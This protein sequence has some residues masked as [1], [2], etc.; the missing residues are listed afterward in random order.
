M[1]GGYGGIF[2]YNC[3]LRKPDLFVII[4]IV[5]SALRAVRRLNL[6]KGPGRGSMMGWCTLVELAKHKVA[7]DDLVGITLGGGVGRLAAEGAVQ[8]SLLGGDGLDVVG[9][10]V[11]SV[12]GEDGATGHEGLGGDGV[13]AGRPHLVDT[14]QVLG[15]DNGRD[16]KVGDAVPALEGHLAQHTAG[17]VGILGDG[18]PVADPALREGG[19]L[20]GLAGD[21]DRVE[22]GVALAGGEDDL[23][24]GAVEADKGDGVGGSGNGAGDDGQGSDL[25]EETHLE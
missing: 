18:V 4:V 19:S 17:V 21:L 24:V 8:L 6:K 23:A 12:A 14:V 2:V 7:G 10:V 1:N 9:K 11:G 22:L 15:V 25:G 3:S 16:I 20:G 13:L 5:C